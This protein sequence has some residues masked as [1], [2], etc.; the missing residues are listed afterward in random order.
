MRLDSI[1]AHLVDLSTTAICA[2]RNV[3]FSEPSGHLCRESNADEL[4]N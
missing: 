3:V 4:I 2:F 1:V